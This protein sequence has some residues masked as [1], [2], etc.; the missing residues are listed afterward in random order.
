MA[1][2]R[3]G[4]NPIK[5]DAT[6]CLEA[7][8][9]DNGRSR[10]IILLLGDPHALEGRQGG[11]DGS[12]NPDRVLALRWS[13]NLHLDT[14]RSQGSDLLGHTLTDAWEHGGTSRQHNVGIQ[15]LA[16]INITLH[17][18]VKGSL[19]NTRGFQT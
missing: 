16:D 12:S 18:G 6:R 4:Q 15:V 8:A 9:V 14:G 13:Y 11:Q 5:N 10:L 19:V 1:T 17:D 2:P 3:M 7:L